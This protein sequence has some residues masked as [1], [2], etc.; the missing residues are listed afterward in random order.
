[1]ISTGEAI[2]YIEYLDHGLVSDLNAIKKKPLTLWTT[3]KVFK[4]DE[5]FIAVV[6]SGTKHRLP[7]SKPTYEIIVK[8]AIT[9][10]ELIH[11]VE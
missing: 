6:C 5:D 8:S 4:E 11:I 9:K 7:N 3:G 10:K 1:M 2:Y